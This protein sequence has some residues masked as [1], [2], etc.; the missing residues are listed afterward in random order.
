[1][2]NNDIICPNCNSICY[3]CLDGWG[4]T[5]FHLHCDKCNINIGSTS[6]EK[7]VELFKKY[8]KPKTFLEYYQNDI[9]ILFEEGKEV[10]NAE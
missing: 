5:P 2:Q 3:F 10:I 7:C 6:E 1:M 4:Y 9:K 8:H